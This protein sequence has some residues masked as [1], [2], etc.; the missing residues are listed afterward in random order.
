[1]INIDCSPEINGSNGGCRERGQQNHGRC[2]AEHLCAR[3]RWT[4]VAMEG[5]AH[6]QQAD[7]LKE[8]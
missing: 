3:Q 8:A 5:T 6:S 7:L 1:M 2:L 4:V